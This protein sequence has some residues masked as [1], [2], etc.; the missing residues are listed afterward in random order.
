MKTLVLHP[1]DST[2]DFLKDIY[3]GKDWTI[4]N[5]PPS[6]SALTKL[7]KE[8]DRIIMLGH[9]TEKGLLTPIYRGNVKVNFRFI[10]DS[11]F[12]YLLR[13]KEC[14]CIWCNTDQF[15]E[16]Y[17]INGF[18]TGMIISEYD[19]ALMF[20]IYPFTEKDINESNTLFQE[21]VK[22]S[23]DSAYMLNEMITNYNTDNNPIINFNKQ[24]LYK[25]IW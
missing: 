17:K 20:S 19:E 7:I 10:I 22:K 5:T 23:I 11:S 2:T 24:N 14:V 21:C 8:H 4:V 9:G 1:T 16:K 13:Q 12:V 3:S 15:V 25:K 6:K 18:Y